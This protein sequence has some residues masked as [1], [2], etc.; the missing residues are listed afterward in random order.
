MNVQNLPFIDIGRGGPVALFMESDE[1]MVIFRAEGKDDLV[2][3]TLPSS[4]KGSLTWPRSS[5]PCQSL[6]R[7]LEQIQH[8]P[9]ASFRLKKVIRQYCEYSLTNPD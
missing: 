9:L 3:E 6:L 7:M 2:Q 5:A 4:A 1:F 8:F